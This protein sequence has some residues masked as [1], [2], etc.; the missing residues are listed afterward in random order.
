MYSSNRNDNFFKTSKFKPIVTKYIS[1]DTNDFTKITKT[2]YKKPE[3]FQELQQQNSEALKRNKE[4]LKQNQNS[5][6]NCYLNLTHTNPTLIDYQ[7]YNLGEYLNK[8]NPMIYQNNINEKILTKQILPLH[9]STEKLLQKL[10]IQNS[11]KKQKHHI[12]LQ[13]K[14]E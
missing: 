14:L 6:L 7:K 8:R 13:K 3:T 1:D 4:S 5:I 12:Y 10:K 11:T 2:G 9:Y